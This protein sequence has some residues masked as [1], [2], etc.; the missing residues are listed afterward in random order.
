MPKMKWVGALIVAATLSV[1]ATTAHAGTIE[2][3]GDASTVAF[4]KG[5]GG[6]FKV[7]SITGLSV[8]DQGTGVSDFV[9]PVSAGVFQTFCL[10]LGVSITLGATLQFDLNTESVQGTKTRALTNEVAY[11]YTQFS[12]GSLSSYDYN[13]GA[14][15]EDDA[16][17]LQDAIWYL[18]GGGTY[19]SGSN[20]FT[21]GDW[22]TEGVLSADS[23]T[24]IKEATNAGWTDIGDVRVLNVYKIVNGTRVDEQDQLVMVPLPPAAL[25]GLMLLGGLGLIGM[26]RRKRST[27]TV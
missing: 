13:T 17:S 16:Q 14:G 19:N 23:K 27:T 10:E 9:S 7:R 12:R 24:W 21:D 1:T 22:L 18:Q 15:R 25:T 11:L 8:P 4:R 3:T 20:T 26:R 5:N 6:E 2:L